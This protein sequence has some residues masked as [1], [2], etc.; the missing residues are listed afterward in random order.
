MRDKCGFTLRVSLH[1]RR[2]FRRKRSRWG[3][4][5]GTALDAEF[6][7][8]NSRGTVNY[9]TLEGKEQRIS[10]LFL[11]TD[12]FRARGIEGKETLFVLPCFNYTFCSNS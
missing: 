10:V 2:V 3:K 6:L 12:P 7:R 5:R 11:V 9:P 1:Q 4:S 8:A